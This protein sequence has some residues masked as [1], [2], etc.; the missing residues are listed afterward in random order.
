MVLAGMLG[1]Y[2]SGTSV[3]TPGL[4]TCTTYGGSE[5]LWYMCFNRG[6]PC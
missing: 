1:A 6:V 5:D 3:Y 4:G 2:F